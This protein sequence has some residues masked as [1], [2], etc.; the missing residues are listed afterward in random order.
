MKL[1]LFFLVLSC[2]VTG[3]KNKDLP[4]KHLS[5]ISVIRETESKP[6]TPSPTENPAES[7][8]Q[9]PASPAPQLSQTRYHVIVSS[10]GATEKARAE[11]LVSQL[12]A[13]NYPATLIYSSQRYRVS[14]E[15]FLTESEANTARDEYRAITDRQDIWVHKVN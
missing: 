3:C 1:V 2:F 7:P 6:V 12:K 9:Q 5:T 15:S 10:F 4:S 14:I 13:K 11:K 8:I